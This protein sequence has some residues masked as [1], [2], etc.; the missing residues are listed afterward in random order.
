MPKEQQRL[1]EAAATV[2]LVG[3]LPI[4]W[5]D[6]AQYIRAFGLSKALWGWVARV[7][8]QQDMDKFQ[9]SVWKALRIPAGSNLHLRNVLVGGTLNMRIVLACRTFGTAVR[10]MA[11]GAL[12]WSAC[13]STLTGQ[14]RKTMRAHGWLEAGQY[15]WRHPA[16]GEEL[17][18][19]EKRGG[20]KDREEGKAKAKAKAKEKADAKAKAKAKEKVHEKAKAEVKAAV[21]EAAHYLREGWRAEEWNKFLRSKRRDSAMLNGFGYPGRRAAEDRAACERDGHMRSILLGTF[22]ITS[23]DGAHGR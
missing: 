17:N 3:T 2:D 21:A 12:R 1:D 14:I 19:V 23:D 22:Q 18:L 20:P 5:R 9:R 11:H 16:T 7:P 4:G 15:N 10:R 6:R 8:T 13:A